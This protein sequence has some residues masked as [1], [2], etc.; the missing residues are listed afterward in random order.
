MKN[1]WKVLFDRLNEASLYTDY[2][3]KKTHFD[4]PFRKKRGLTLK[5]VQQKVDPFDCFFLIFFF[6]S[7]CNSNQGQ[8][9]LFFFIQWIKKLHKA[10]RHHMNITSFFINRKNYRKRVQLFWTPLMVKPFFFLPKMVHQNEF[11]FLHCNQCLNTL[12][13]SYLKALSTVQPCTTHS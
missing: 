2:D 8:F 13:L 7:K 11:W 6:F 3:A 1:Q 5:G 10:L 9:F 4:G 12:H